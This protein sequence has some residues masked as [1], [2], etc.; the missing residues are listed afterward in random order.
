MGRYRDNGEGMDVSDVFWQEEKDVLSVF[1]RAAANAHDAHLMGTRGELPMVD[2]LNRYIPGTMT[3]ATGRIG[4]PNG[5]ISGPVDIIVSDVRY[6]MLSQYADGSMIVP[7]HAVLAAVAVRPVLDLSTLD[8]VLKQADDVYRLL[9]VLRG[10]PENEGS[11][12]AG[13]LFYQANVTL[14]ELRWFLPNTA[15]RNEFPDLAV[16]RLHRDDQ[17]AYPDYGAE[18][19]IGK[20]TEGRPVMGVSPEQGVLHRFYSDLVGSSYSLLGL[21][22][23]DIEAIGDRLSAYREWSCFPFEDFFPTRNRAGGGNGEAGQSDDAGSSGSG[24]GPEGDWRE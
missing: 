23:H 14:P 10:S 17:V 21:R 6:P 19:R 18:I 9:D 13:G 12:K 16:L 4:M 15:G 5:D 20:K 1:E 24:Y 11:P 8:E 22:D 2:F 7:L 3:A